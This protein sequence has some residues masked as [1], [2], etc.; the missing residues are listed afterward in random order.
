[1]TE[2]EISRSEETA[3]SSYRTTPVS[4]SHSEGTRNNKIIR[5]VILT[6]SYILYSGQTWTK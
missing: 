2:E 6:M 3:A 4:Q 5:Q 1:M